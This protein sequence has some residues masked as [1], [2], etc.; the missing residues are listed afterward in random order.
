MKKI[1]YRKLISK[2]N[3][4][5]LNIYIRRSKT[6]NA[7]I[8]QLKI[9][10]IEFNKFLHKRRIFNVLTAYYLCDK[11]HIIVKHV[12][13]FCSNW[14]KKRKKILQKAKIINIKRLFS[15]RKT[16][17]IVVCM[18]LTIGLLKQFQTTKLSKE[19]KIS[20]L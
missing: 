16:I 5:H 3:H 4:R 6:Y 20:R 19:K 13:L 11:K 15:E 7:L 17:T 9:N 12:L 18:I 10:K 14:R 2:V 8:I 1:Q